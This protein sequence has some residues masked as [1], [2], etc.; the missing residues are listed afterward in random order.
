[1]HAF[2]SNI[3]FPLSLFDSFRNQFGSQESEQCENWQPVKLLTKVIRLSTD[4]LVQ[5]L[6]YQES[7]ASCQQK[8]PI[9]QICHIR[10]S[11]ACCVQMTGTTHI[12]GTL[13][14]MFADLLLFECSFVGLLAFSATVGYID[15]T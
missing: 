10:L 11:I 7:F 13:L 2:F 14:C 3:I 5:G 1:M 6:E 4:S 9:S 12:D 15:Y 8:R